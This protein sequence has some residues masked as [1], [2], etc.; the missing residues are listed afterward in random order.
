MANLE[1]AKLKVAQWV[2]ITVVSGISSILLVGIIL[3]FM[4]PA[5]GDEIFRNIFGSLIPLLGT[6]MGTLLAYYFSKENFEAASNSLNQALAS[7]TS[8]QKLASISVE[9][10]M[11]NVTSITRFVRKLKPGEIDDTI[12]IKEVLEFINDYPKAYRIPFITKDNK[13]LYIIHTSIFEKYFSSKSMEGKSKAD[14]EIL[15]LKDMKDDVKFKKYFED[16]A[17][18]IKLSSNLKDA[19]DELD[20][21]EICRDIF[22]TQTGKKDEPILGWIPDGL[23]L[24]NAKV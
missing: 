8:D 22:V 16:G 1:D 18:F 13:L 6:W 9:K 23:I 21:H 2:F 20:D 12:T 17:S 11:I 14:I 10:V 24:E 3:I 15:T 19:Q 5:N 4:F 7:V